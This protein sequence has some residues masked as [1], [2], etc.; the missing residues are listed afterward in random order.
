ME[1]PKYL[2]DGKSDVAIC[3]VGIVPLGEFVAACECIK[4]ASERLSSC[5]LFSRIGKLDIFMP[6]M[7]LDLVGADGRLYSGASFSLS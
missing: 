2:T 3:P 1:L 5:D 6:V 7:E 4:V